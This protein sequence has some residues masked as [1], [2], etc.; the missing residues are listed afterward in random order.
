MSSLNYAGKTRIINLARPIKKGPAN[1]PQSWSKKRPLL[2]QGSRVKRL[3]QQGQHGLAGLVGLRQH[4]GGSLLD[5]L[6]LGQVGG[7]FGVV[8]VQNTAA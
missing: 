2:A 7:L 5:D 6:R 3:L 8:G 4:G 1:R